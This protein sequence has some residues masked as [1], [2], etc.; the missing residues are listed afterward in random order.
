MAGIIRGDIEQITQSAT[1]LSDFSSTL[2][3]TLTSLKSTVDDISNMTYGSA[4]ETLLTTYY[5]LDKDLRTYVQELETLGKNV[6][7]SSN[8]LESIDESASSGLS[9]N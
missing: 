1:K 5:A 7:T 6:Q 2:D 8:N 4:S 3:T 9:Y